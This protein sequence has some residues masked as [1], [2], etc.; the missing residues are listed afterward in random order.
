MD[1]YYMWT[2]DYNRYDNARSDWLLLWHYRICPRTDYGP[3]EVKE[4]ALC[5]KQIINLKRSIYSL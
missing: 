5:N 3:A 4:K 2:Y 1:N